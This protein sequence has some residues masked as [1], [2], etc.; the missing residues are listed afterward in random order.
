M[1]DS[2]ACRKGQVLVKGKCITLSDDDFIIISNDE[3]KSWSAI[4]DVAKGRAKKMAIETG[5]GHSI[6][7]Y[8][9]TFEGSSG[10]EMR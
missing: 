8:I 3:L 2:K 6:Y 10:R 7:K 5:S 9:S 1:K 4:L